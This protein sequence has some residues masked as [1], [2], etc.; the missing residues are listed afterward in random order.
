MRERLESL[1]QSPWEE[2]WVATFHSFCTRLLEE[3]A[4]DAGIDPFVVA[5]NPAD[6]LALMLDR[7]EDLT[8]RRHEIR[9]NPAPLT[10]QLHREDRPAQGRDGQ[11]RA[12]RGLGAELASGAAEATP[13]GPA[14]SGSWSSRRCM[15]TTTGCWPGMGRSTS[16]T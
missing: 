15:R 8:L 3:E 14:R 16:A 4:L 2:L 9:G 11:R 7:I 5:G 1:I 13:S 12:L 6:R 10:R